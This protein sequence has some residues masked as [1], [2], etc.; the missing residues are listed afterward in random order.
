M[1][2]AGETAVVVEVPCFEGE[3]IAQLGAKEFANR[4]KRR[5]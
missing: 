3:A 2:P 4:W 5:G 1:A